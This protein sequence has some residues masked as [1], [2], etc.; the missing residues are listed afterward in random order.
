MPD[1][2]LE[3]VVEVDV[4]KANASIKTV[5]AG[6][7]SIE[8][9]ASK[10]ARGAS[11]GIDGLTASMVRGAT[12]GSLLADSIRH[13]LEWVKEWTIEAA[14]HAANTERM[15]V[16]TK[17][18]AARHGESAEA[19]MKV[20]EAVKR[21]GFT[22][23]DAE[24][25]VQ[26]MIIADLSLDKAEGLARVAKDAAAVSTSGL[27][28]SEA[29]EQIVTAIE[30]GRGRGLR[31]LRIFV[32]LNK[33]TE[34]AQKL[35][36]L[37]GR[38]LTEN[39][40]IEVRH[41]AIMREATKLQGA[42]ASQTD[43]LQAQTQAL[44]RE[45]DAL[46]EAVGSQFQGLLKEWVVHLRELVGFLKD[47]SSLV[48][49]FAEGVL[50]LAG[51]LG[52]VTVAMKAFKLGAAGLEATL[53]G[54]TM[55]RNVSFAFSNGLTGALV[56][57]EVVLA[58]IARL[59]PPVAAGLAV[60]WGGNK[61]LEHAQGN[62]QLDTTAEAIKKINARL[63]ET[64]EWWI[65]HGMTP[66]KSRIDTIVDY[67]KTLDSKKPTTKREP[68]DAELD[69]MLA[70]R[71]TRLDAERA[72]Q[73]YYLRA[74]EERKSAEHDMAR[75]RIEDSMKIIEATQSETEAA[76]ESLD[77]VLLSMQERKAGREKILQEEAR[78]L[79]RLS[80][81]VD[82]KTG[83]IQHVTLNQ[84]TLETLHKSTAEKLAAFDMRF[85]EEEDRRIQAMLKA[86][87]ARSQKLFE[88]LYVEPMKQQL[89][90]WEQKQDWQEKIDDQTRAARIAAVDQRKDLELARLDAV[91]AV[92]IQD[93]IR[94]EQTKTAIE[95]QAL[96]ERARIEMEQIDAR[97]E[98]QVA[99]ARKAAM[100][101]G[102]F[103]EPYLQEIESKIRDLGSR[104][105]D[106]LQ[107][108]ATSDVA[109]AQAKGAAATRKIV[110]DE[111]RSIFQTLK[112]E[113]GGVFDA[114]VTKSQSV[115]AAI[116]N[117]LK[118]ALLTAI[119]DVVTSRI[120][121]A[122]MNLFVPG[123]GV[124]MQQSGT[125]RAGGGGI[126][127]KLG[128]I[129]GVGAVP[130][131]G[132]SGAQGGTPPFVPSTSGGNSGMGAATATGGIF[133]KAGL[134]GFF[135]GLKSFL[136]FGDNKWVDLGGGRMATGGWIG[137]YGSLGDK[138]KALGK[139][140]AAAMAGGLLALDGLRRG[141]YAGLAET[142]AGGAMIG[143]K[144]GGPLGA[145]IG[146][147]AG[148]V[149]GIV[150]LFVKGAVDKAKEKIKALYGVDISDKGVLQQIVDT[151][152]SA[153][154]GNLDLAIR[155]PQIRDLI[156]LY[157]MSTGQKPTGM[158]GT[159]TPVSL[160]ETGGSLFQAPSYSNGTPLPGLSG[161][162]GLDQI[163][164]GTA[165][166]GGLVIQLDGPATTALLRGEAVQAIADNPRVVQSAA[167]AATKSN[168]SR[169]EMT[170]LQLS[171]G[172]I[173]A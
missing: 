51:A 78:E 132:G 170:A 107:K 153:F 121:M 42:A 118:T 96:Q 45:V 73:D 67:I 63:R 19:A 87:A 35:A 161:L 134:A 117:S 33:E 100:A 141:G 56:G 10:A 171:P 81:R 136:G 162:P 95:V 158:P 169:R 157:A 36:E 57:T 8:Q 152:K 69:R 29:M 130:V 38:T 114:L 24:G 131:F 71:K 84:S 70:D 83:V 11:S 27:K 110:V 22:M 9:S 89:Y 101:Q 34:R 50:V 106:A 111:Y 128:G 140:D 60:W 137:Q 149:A 159:V 55:L 40:I 93:K 102:I 112:Q 64:P 31:E 49:K 21:I 91:D 30:S 105:K 82:E 54:L 143:Y 122:L 28:A 144:F 151:A 59:L 25:A 77:V 139:S 16:V 47:N 6:L 124:Q 99:E 46:R 62:K 126:L 85:N 92:T 58:N 44:S 68:T 145:A 18:L 48:V 166:G 172:T 138:L 165:S 15:E 20:V 52:T 86:S 1:N 74:V 7:S 98:R 5:N 76:R 108:A 150:R 135:P 146:A 119:K 43:S 66:P 133:S 53:G 2:K 168:A 120:A 94:L 127:G 26:K 125:P 103:Y 148:A 65:Q 163:G 17:A 155:S 79:A 113:A 23:A 154:G 164:A 156:Q 32:D 90:V 167:M 116:G 173:T 109:V 104:E 12:A 14:R 3:L 13:A 142:T 147:V 75:S 72:S 41:A 160:V 4:N 115:W 97:T 61:L 129:F 88:Q 37:Q 123:S 80:T 39:E